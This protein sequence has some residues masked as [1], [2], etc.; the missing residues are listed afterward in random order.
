MQEDKDRKKYDKYPNGRYISHVEEVQQILGYPEVSTNMNFINIA[1]M[2][3]EY[4]PGIELENF[5]ISKIPNNDSAQTGSVSNDIRCSIQ[6]MFIVY[7][8]DIIII[9]ICIENYLNFFI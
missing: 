3:L 5:V 8:I 6:G 7:L 1:T 2:P 9:F 4:R